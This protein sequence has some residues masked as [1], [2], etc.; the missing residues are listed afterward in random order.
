M[1][2]WGCVNQER[3]EGSFLWWKTSL[4]LKGLINVFA[5]DF[6]DHLG[7]AFQ[8]GCVS[9]VFTDCSWSS[10]PVS[11]ED[12]S[13]KLAGYHSTTKY[14]L[15]DYLSRMLVTISLHSSCM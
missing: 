13:L 4:E 11:T 5:S 6:L 7:P 8:N 10:A 1:Y 14:R 9:T 12:Q 15:P 3:N 2:F